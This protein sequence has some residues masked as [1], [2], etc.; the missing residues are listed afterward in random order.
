MN[1]RCTRDRFGGLALIPNPT[2]FYMASIEE[3]GARAGKQA[4]DLHKARER[5]GTHDSSKNICHRERE[6]S[7]A[8]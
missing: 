2:G 8:R 3:V 5:E 6:D 1:T 4:A 7:A